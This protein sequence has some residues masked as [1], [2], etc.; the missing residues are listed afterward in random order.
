MKDSVTTAEALRLAGSVR[1][2][3]RGSY[4]SLLTLCI[5]HILMGFVFDR[6]SN[7][8]S[9]HAVMVLLFGIFTVVRARKAHEVMPVL[10]YIAGAEVLW[11]M[12]EGNPVWEYG[13]Y[14]SLVIA[15]FT[16]VKFGR[17][18]R[19]TDLQFALLALLLLFPAT[20]KTMGMLPFNDARQQLSF[21]LSGPVSLVILYLFSRML[22]LNR[23]QW[24]KTLRSVLYPVV[25]IATIGFYWT[26]TAKHIRFSLS[27][28]FITSGGFGPN[29]VSAVLGFGALACMFLFVLDGKTFNRMIYTALFVWFTTQALLT[30]SRGGVFNLVVAGMFFVL[31]FIRHRRTRIVLISFLVVIGLLLS[32]FLVP[33][34]N[35][36]TG[37]MLGR[38][39]TEIDTTGR[40]NFMKAD[41]E[42]W[43]N[44]P[45]MGVGVGLSK[46]EHTKISGRP[47]AAHTEF[48]RL[49]AEHGLLGLIFLV[50]LGLRVVN[51]YLNKNGAFQKG[52]AGALAGWALLEMSHAAMR[53][54]LISFS[55]ALAFVHHIPHEPVYSK[56][57]KKM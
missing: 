41:I 30:F 29:Q 9:I 57:P 13:K 31:Q 3:T 15:L 5:L 1:V 26:M 35:E 20:L 49:L 7:I 37:G 52:I 8:S 10:A 47:V 38:R 40:S 50:L 44:N 43:L 39:F 54:V 55:F 28:N 23:V 53:I 33:W 42:T 45:I 12:T 25:S 48:S 18:I 14:S 4:L 32:L 2:N 24:I 56:K 19:K 21:N 16:L 27:S 36:F 46:Y 34:L 17:G 11:R 22:F 6:A 51:E